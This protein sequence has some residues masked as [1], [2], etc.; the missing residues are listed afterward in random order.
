MKQVEIKN[1]MVKNRKGKMIVADE[2]FDV[3]IKNGRSVRTYSMEEAL[4]VKSQLQEELKS[5]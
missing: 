2:V 4:I 3:V 5:L 1:V